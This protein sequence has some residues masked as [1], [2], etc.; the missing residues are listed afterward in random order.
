[1]A[2]NSDATTDDLV[3]SFASSFVQPSVVADCPTGGDVRRATANVI[4]SW[5]T[6]QAARGIANASGIP[7]GFFREGRDAAISLTQVDPSEQVAWIEHNQRAILD[8]SA[9]PQPVP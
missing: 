6:L 1:M 9:V 8:C 2:I 7:K 5:L 3:Y 4:V